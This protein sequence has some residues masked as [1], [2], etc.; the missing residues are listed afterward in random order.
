[1]C[2][3]ILN[4][5]I[6]DD[7]DLRNVTNA[8]PDR[9]MS[10][11][12]SVDLPSASTVSHFNFLVRL[13]P[14]VSMMGTAASDT[15]TS[16]DVPAMVGLRCAVTVSRPTLPER[17]DPLNSSRARKFAPVLKPTK[18]HERNNVR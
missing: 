7:L 15:E 17:R 8:D 3:N 13:T 14:S 5:N 1:M 4:M 18:G 12:V 6:F 11:Y 9:N 2:W 10:Y 16:K